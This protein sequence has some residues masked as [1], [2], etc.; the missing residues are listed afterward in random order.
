MSDEAEKPGLAGKLTELMADNQSGM[1]D[2]LADLLAVLPPEEAEALKRT[3]LGI[4]AEYE[5]DMGALVEETRAL[6]SDEP[7]SDASPQDGETS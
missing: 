1:E 7:Q 2:M 3:L 4:H 6:E 5:K